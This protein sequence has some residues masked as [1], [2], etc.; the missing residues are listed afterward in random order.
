MMSLFLIASLLSSSVAQPQPPLVQ[1]DAWGADSVRIRIAPPGGAIVDPPFTPLLLPHPSHASAPPASSP[2]SVT[3]GNLRV[4]ADAQGAI[5]ATRLSD[6]ALLFTT[7]GL[8]FAAPAPGSRPGSVAAAVTLHVPGSNKLY[9][10]GEHRTGVLDA[11]GYAKRLEDSQFY[12]QSHGADVMIP[13]YAAH[14]LGLGVLWCLPSF[15]NVSLAAEGHLWS[16]AATLNI[17][18]WV[19]TTPA[20]PPQEAAEDPAA[21]SPLAALLSNFVDAVG[22]AAPMPSYV[23]GFWACKNRYRKQSQVLDVARGYRER[24][25]PLDIITVD[26]MHWAEFGDWKFNPVCWPDVPGMIQELSDM[27]VELAVTFWPYVTPAGAYFEPFTNSGYFATNLTGGAIAVETW[28]GQMALVDETNAAARAAIYAA[29]KEGYGQFGVRTVW[30]DGSEPER[31][32][33][34]NF[35][36]LRL[37][38]GTD[39]EVGEAW[40]QQHLRA[41]SEGFASDGFAPDEFFLLPRSAWAG[42]SRYSAGLWSGDIE[43]SFEELALQVRVLQ[44]MALSGHALWTNDGGGYAGG[45]PSNAV[46]QELVVRWL[47]ASAFFPIMRLHGQ[48]K[49][50]PPD[51]ECGA[52]GGPN[53]PWTLAPEAAQY[54]AVRACFTPP[55]VFVFVGCFHT[56]PIGQGGGAPPSLPP[57]LFFL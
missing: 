44:Q 48:R 17:D 42:T 36:K 25:L 54:D 10:L 49:G 43:S 33:S 12:P 24:G 5:T 1:L 40:I 45:D 30:L 29:F 2:F 52:T 32:T 16:S 9:G 28:A 11:T 14:P 47:Q 6:A 57:P 15:G 27:G 21:A 19:T 56:P 53:E 13:Y 46:F 22:H 8:S 39:S 4:E 55:G 41:M 51:D 23:A 20:S 31:A 35:G 26:Y 7:G 3:S 18:F 38:A 37:Q 50:G 34:Y